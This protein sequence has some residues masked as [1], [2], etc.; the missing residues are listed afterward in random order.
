MTSFCIDTG[1]VDV[2]IYSS[3]VAVTALFI[4]TIS[5]LVL[6]FCR[7]RVCVGVCVCMCVYE[8]VTVKISVKI[9][10]MYIGNGQETSETAGGGCPQK[11]LWLCV[12]LRA[13]PQTQCEIQQF[14]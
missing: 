4:L 7:Q 10:A 9:V 1:K 6:L 2:I 14:G 8:C 12:Q 3:V 13:E 11:Q 5:L